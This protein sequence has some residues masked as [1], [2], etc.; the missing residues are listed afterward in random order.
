M[1][2][3]ESVPQVYY[4]PLHVYH[5]EFDNLPLRNIIF[6]QQIIN[7]ALDLQISD[8][9]AAR[10]DAG[11]LENR[12]AQSLNDSGQLKDTAIDLALHN[13]ASHTDGSIDISGTPVSFVRMLDD[14]RDKL[15][16]I[17]D[18]ATNFSLRFETVGPS[19]TPVTFDDG[20]LP[21]EDSSTVTWR[22]D[23]GGS[24]LADMVFPTSAAH[25]HV[26]DAEAIS[27]S[28]SSPDY[29]NYKSTSISTAYVEDSLRVYINGSR[30]SQDELIYAPGPTP[31]DDFVLIGY[32][33]SPSA[34][35]FVLTTAITAS[36]VIRIDF[37]IALA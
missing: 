17:T 29:T 32:T 35:T 13:I 20:I 2:N 18:E 27:A 8:M 25:Q 6:R 30:L 9:S 22:L 12:L 4:E 5:Y 14:E 23:S 36:D 16:L 7:S 11:T 1:P 24:I 21:I 19:L 28:L 26:Y 34:G 10:G 15:A 33:E 31:T 3:I 37:D